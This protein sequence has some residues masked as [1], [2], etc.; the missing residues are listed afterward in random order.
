MCGIAG[1]VDFSARDVD[2]IK[3][4][5][6]TSCLAHRGPDDESYHFERHVGLGHRRLSIID[7]EG[8]KQPMAGEDGSM[9]VYNGEVY[10]F[11]E[12]RKELEDTGHRFKTRSDTEVILRAY[13]QWGVDC[14]ERLNGM[15]AF[16]IW[17]PKR[18]RLFIAR[19]RIGI[20]PLVY[21]FE[22]QGMLFC[23][24]VKALAAC[25]DTK[26]KLDSFGLV[27]Y[28]LLQYVPGENTILEGIKR[29]EPGEAALFS[30]DGFK[31]WK[32]W[33]LPDSSSPV[34]G[35]RETE[36]LDLLDDS[37][38]LRLISD[39][40]LGAFLSGGIDSSIIVGLMN[41]HAESG[42]K[43]YQV[44]FEDPPGYDETPWA[45]LASRRFGTEHSRTV[46]EPAELSEL[47]PRIADRMGE[48]VAD[49]A[50]IP[51]YIISELSRREVAVVLTGEGG[52][53]L[54]AGY[55]RY[56]LARYA[57]AWR[58]IP[59]W[60]R[61]V[62]WGSAGAF[63]QA[64]R[65]R[66]AIEALNSS[67]GVWGHL[68][69][70]RVLDPLELGALFPDYDVPELL[71]KVVGHFEPYF[72][73]VN[74]KGALRATLN[75]DLNTWLPCDLLAKVDLMSMAHGLEAR[76]P[77]LD[78]RIV[79]FAVGLDEKLLM[80]SKEGK[81]ILKNAARSLVPAEILRRGKKGFTVPLDHWFQSTL[82]GFLCEAVELAVK[83]LPLDKHVAVKWVDQELAGERDF[84]LR[85][86]A[87]CLLGFWLEGFN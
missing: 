82:R 7:I 49:P 57:R 63:R 1:I 76:V 3:V 30:P 71:E 38:R 77:Y 47:L 31:K 51:T 4:H 22:G 60:L 8:G 39:V 32:W 27:G 6:M 20:K 37:V 34:K 16:A 79:E 48:P 62:G 14:L 40:P 12:L 87:L 17:D 66:K 74:D 15:F 68:A 45:E 13:E 35:G 19:D 28:F 80:S 65:W 73:G 44:A 24:E 70:V 61:R 41:R 52:D 75:C 46:M 53:E 25:L 81:L 59:R 78:H 10:N 64:D 21:A 23:S 33:K 56:R 36:L 83:H 69:W 26:P 43:T 58:I 67:P 55:L 9:I 29:L 84:G 11:A 54:F 18:R 86:F 50:L 2:R 85:L 5:A 42:L 72:I